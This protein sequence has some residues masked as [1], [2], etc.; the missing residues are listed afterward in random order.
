M[1]TSSSLMSMP[2]YF[3]FYKHNHLHIIFIDSMCNLLLYQKAI[4]R[5]M[6]EWMDGWMD[7]WVDALMHRYMDVWMH[8]CLTCKLYD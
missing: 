5:L 3:H 7:G 4:E 2:P 6:D 8:G 1:L